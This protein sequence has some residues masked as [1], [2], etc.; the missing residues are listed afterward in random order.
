MN[1][2][3]VIANPAHEGLFLG[4]VSRLKLLFGLEKKILALIFSYALTIGLFSLVVPLTVQELVNTFA[5]AIQPIT[6]ATLTGIMAC[7]LLFIAAFKV[8]Q[9]RAVE[10]LQQ[11]VYTRIAV[12]FTQALPHVREERFLP[13]HANYLSEAEFLTRAALAV[14]ADLM[15]ILVAGAI[16]MTILVLYHPYF[17]VFNLLLV[18]GFATVVILLGQGGLKITLEMSR[19]HYDTL[20]WVQNV[21]HNLPYFKATNSRGLLLGK[22]DELVRQYVL[23]RQTRSDILT[24][25]QFKGAVIWQALGH[26]GLL[27]TAGMLLATGQITLGQFVASE[28]IVGALL[29]NLETLARRMYALFFVFSSLQ[30][31]SGV[32]GLPRDDRQ[33]KVADLARDQAHYGIRL[34]GK[35]LAFGFP[36]S[37]PL[38]RDFSLEVNPGEKVA[39]ISRTSTV[40]TAL[41]RVLAGLY[42]P[43]AGVVRYNDV[44]LRDASLDSIN[45]VRSL[46]L[47]SHLTLFEGTLEENIALGRPSISYSDLQWALWFAELEEDVD[48]LP[49]GLHSPVTSQ[50]RPFTISQILRILVARAVV[51]RPRILIFA[52]ALHAMSPRTRATILRRLCSKDEG[53]SVIFVTNDP[54]IRTEVD[55]CIE[56]E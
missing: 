5:F 10:T 44:D 39:V 31:L 33:G 3:R 16:G 15:N 29:L 13:R 46:V 42:T 14:L 25:Q 54:S 24:G 53:W 4:T 2:A 22:T 36:G 43:T 35:N 49:A 41:A 32:F 12:G 50:G 6:I 20:D 51:I 45:A 38:F 28:V 23:I 21:A 8:L 47:D 26:S 55:R 56:I 40:K 1:T 9:A 30:E 11:R 19:L 37:A 48:A 52:G 17:L 18:G 27:A 34:T 7:T